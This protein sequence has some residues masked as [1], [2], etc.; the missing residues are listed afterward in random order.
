MD[1]FLKVLENFMV[2]DCLGLQPFSLMPRGPTLLMALVSMKIFR[3]EMGG[4]RTFWNSFTSLQ[5]RVS[6]LLIFC[7]FKRFL[8]TFV[9]VVI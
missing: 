4:R 8:L 9:V 1:F 6:L 7:K 5:T 2:M 3:L